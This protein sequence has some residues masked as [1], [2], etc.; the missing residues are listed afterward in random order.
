M[1]RFRCAICAQRLLV[2]F[3]RTWNLF[4]SGGRSFTAPECR[5]ALQERFAVWQ[6]AAGLRPSS[7]EETS[8]LRPPTS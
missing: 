7:A 4:R 8:P 2:E 1:G 3:T 5:T 6:A